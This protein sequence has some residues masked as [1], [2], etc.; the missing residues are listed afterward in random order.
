MVL[1]G[2]VAQGG[3]KPTTCAKCGRNYS[4]VCREVS[5]DCFKCGQ[6]G[7]FIRECPKNK[8]EN[9]NGG[10]RAQSF[11]VAPPDRAAPR[12]ATFGTGRGTNRLYAI[13]SRQEQEDSPD[14]VTGMIQVFDLTVYALLDP[15]ASLSFVT[16]YVAMN[17][18]IIPKQLS[19]PF[20]VSTAVG[21]SILAESVYC[22]CPVSVNHKSTMANL[23]ELDMIDFDVILSMD[24]LHACYAL[25]LYFIGGDPYK[26]CESLIAL[27]SFTHTP[28]MF[29]SVKF[30]LKEFDS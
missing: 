28:N 12:G 16:P 26:V 21:E 1:E 22:D 14:V 19:E 4:S 13:T 20:N 6:T 29:S 25:L 11:S 5:T 10:N 15:E 2:S 7:H 27:G 17:F 30:V 3:S 24:W 23:I 8:Q 18:D 9:G